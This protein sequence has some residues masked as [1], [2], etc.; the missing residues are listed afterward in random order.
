MDIPLTQKI[1]QCYVFAVFLYETEQWATTKTLLNN[2]KAFR[3]YIQ[4]VLDQSYFQRRVVA[5]NEKRE[6]NC[7]HD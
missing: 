5:P 1:N 3:E 2:P 6:E 7:V 4:Y